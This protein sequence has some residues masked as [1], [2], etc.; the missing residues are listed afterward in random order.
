MNGEIVRPITT[1]NM[2]EYTYNWEPSKYTDDGDEPI[3]KISKSSLGL[4]EWCPKK[5]EFSYIEKKPQDVSEAMH[6]GT[7][8]HD[9]QEAFY[10]AFDVE[11]ASTYDESRLR[12]Y[13][14]TL[15]PLDDYTDVYDT[16]I[17]YNARR[18]NIY[19]SVDKLDM[20]LP[21]LNEVMLDAEITIEANTSKKFPLKRDYK[22]HLQGIIDRMFGTESSYTPMELKTGKYG[23]WK[24]TS[25]RKEMAF[26][27]ILY[28]NAPH[29]TLIEAG[30]N[31]QFNIE[32]WGWIFPISDVYYTE[33]ISKRSQT[34]V[35]DNIAKLISSYEDGVFA[36][37]YN[38]RMCPDCSYYSICDFANQKPWSDV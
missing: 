38:A 19:K 4:H 12:A 34:A 26:Y 17:N 21:V 24:V 20:F 3:L 7:I 13:M 15:Y 14:H 16:L 6:K 9:A 32:T 35:Y 18:F 29:S 1:E 27:K 25:M 23:K 22:I 28:D 37:K 10:K 30:L 31:P 33:D 36:T 5:Y 8:I 2:R 11:L